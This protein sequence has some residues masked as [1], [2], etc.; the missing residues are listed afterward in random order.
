M[1]LKFPLFPVLQIKFFMFHLLSSVALICSD[2][3]DSDFS[4]VLKPAIAA[5][6]ARD[7]KNI[8]PIPSLL[9]TDSIPNSYIRE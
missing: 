1:L 2:S 4:V 7:L 9:T 8:Y 5:E 6:L 3:H